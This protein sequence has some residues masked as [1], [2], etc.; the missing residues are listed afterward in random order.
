VK[1]GGLKK[2]RQA[3]ISIAFELEGKGKGGENE[4]GKECAVG[5]RSGSH[6]FFQARRKK[7]DK[8]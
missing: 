7:R 8:K 1:K 4:N 3:A 2:D 5:R 6:S